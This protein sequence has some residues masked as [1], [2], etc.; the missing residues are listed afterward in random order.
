MNDT[1]GKITVSGK[2]FNIVLDK[3]TGKIT[4]GKVNGKTTVIGGPDINL[5]RFISLTKWKLNSISCT[6]SGSEAVVT[7]SGSYSE[8]SSVTFNI[9]I[10]GTG[11]MNTEFSAALPGGSVEEIGVTYVMP[12]LKEFSWKSDVYRY[13]VLPDYSVA[14]LN[15]TAVP[16]REG[17]LQNHRLIR[18]YGKS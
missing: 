6:T 16:Y 11:R 15:G 8:V 1:D 4:D 13:S 14:R 10:D 3:S 5:G 17:S 2:S 18:P 7:V 9:K 12:L